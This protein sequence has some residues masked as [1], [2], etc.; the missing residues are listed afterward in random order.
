MTDR[1]DLEAIK[2][3][4]DGQRSVHPA[5]EAIR[6]DALALIAEVERLRADVERARAICEDAAEMQCDCTGY[7][8]CGG[9]ERR[10]AERADDAREVL[11]EETKR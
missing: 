10:I 1:L 6:D 9:C 5:I 7:Y 3:R 2:G 11:G 4:V 8:R